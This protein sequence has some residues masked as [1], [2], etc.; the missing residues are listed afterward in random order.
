MIGGQRELDE[1][2]LAADRG[3]RGLAQRGA[4]RVARDVRRVDIGEATVV[5]ERGERLGIRRGRQRR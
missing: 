4:G 5:D 3:D 1:C 2:I